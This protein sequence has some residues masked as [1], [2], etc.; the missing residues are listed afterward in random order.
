MTKG[1]ALILFATFA[2]AIMNTLAKELSSFPPLQVVFFRAFGTFIFIFPYMLYRKVSLI[3]NHPKI[4]A[5]RALVG[6]VSL[7]TFFMAVQRIPLGSA[8]SIRY[9][10]PIFGA[11][12]AAYFLKEKI[13]P[14]QWLSFAIGF[15]GVIV[16]KGFDLRIDYYSL[17]L[18][19]ISALFVGMVFVLIRYLSTREHYLTIINYFMVVSI[20]VSLC[21]ISTWRM[22]VGTE[23]WSVIG[24]GI[25]GLVGQV[26]MTQAFR[27]E[28]TSALAPFK[29][30]ELVWALF[31]GF[32]FFKETY[33]WLPF[34]GILL[35]IAG[36]LLNVFGKNKKATPA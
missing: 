20:S 8:I 7:A 32:F 14:W 27:T 33:E 21:F 15:S 1:I 28:E 34:L 30:M 26:T 5:L 18:L 19:I 24:I 22:P 25:F 12:L 31:L 2:F 10:G 4:L 17:G 16:L 3:G 36:M 29:Y 11:M 23:W 9:L 13:T 6:V 35:I